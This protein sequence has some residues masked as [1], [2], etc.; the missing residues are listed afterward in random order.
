MTRKWFPNAILQLTHFH[1]NGSQN[2]VK[3]HLQ[4]TRYATAGDQGEAKG[5]IDRTLVRFL[6]YGHK[7]MTQNISQAVRSNPI[8]TNP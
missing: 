2:A 1:L 7:N 6:D 3:I 4:P 5:D 8:I